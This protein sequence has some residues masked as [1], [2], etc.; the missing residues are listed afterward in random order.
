MGWARRIGT[1]DLSIQIREFCSLERHSNAS[2]TLEEVLREEEKLEFDPSSAEFR[3]YSPAPRERAP[4]P[5]GV[6]VIN[7][8]R[9]DVRLDELRP[10]RAYVFVC[11]AGVSAKLY[12][13]RARERGIEAYALSE[14]EAREMGL[15]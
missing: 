6:V 1:Y 9:E 14:E 4:P 10:G 8:E 5:A 7:L 15:L 11:R 3:G 13:D 2:A 12:A